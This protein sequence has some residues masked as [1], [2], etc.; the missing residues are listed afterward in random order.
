MSVSPVPS[1]LFYVTDRSCGLRFL[2]D[3]GAEVSVIPP[4]STERRHPHENLTLQAINST[5]IATYGTHSLTLD[6]GF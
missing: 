4:S 3:T 5:P 2:V 6:L 1:H